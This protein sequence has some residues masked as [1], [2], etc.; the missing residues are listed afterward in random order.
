MTSGR[1]IFIKVS[2]KTSSET[3]ETFVKIRNRVNQK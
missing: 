1:H 2:D 3:F